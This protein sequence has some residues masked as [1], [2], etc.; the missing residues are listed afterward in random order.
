MIPRETV[1]KILDAAQIVEVVSDFVTLKKR[2][3]DF[4]ACCPFHNEKTP[5]FHVSQ[6]RGFYKCF[7]CGKS[8]T[9][10]GFVMEHETLS[11]VDA[12]KWLARKYHIEVVEKEETAEE[13]AARQRGESLMLVTQF[14]AEFFAKQ[15]REGEGRAVGYAY[16]KMRKLEDETITKFG[17]G[18]APKGRD[19]L[20]RAAREAGYKE[21]FLIEAGLSVKRDDGSLADRFFER[22]MFP[23]CSD[24]GRVIGFG[25]RTLKKDDNI[26]KYIN[27]SE[28]EIYKKSRVLYGMNFAKGEI[29]RKGKC[30]LVEGY[31]DVISMHQLGLTNVVASSGTALTEE[32]V[33]LIHKFTE[34]VT[35]IYDA[36]PAGIHAAL[37][38]IDLVLREGLN[39]KILLLP[40]GEDPD[41]FAHKKTLAEVGAYIEG[42]EQDFIGFKTD[43]L[44]GDAGDDPLK[45]AN[46]VND[47]ADTIAQ[48][49]D[50]VKRATYLESTSRRFGIDSDSI[51]RRISSTREKI[52]L[53][54]KRQREARRRAASQS[55]SSGGGVQDGSWQNGYSTEGLESWNVPEVPVDGGV[56]GSAGGS[57][58]VFNAPRLQPCERELLEFV[59]NSGQK[60]ME[61][62]SD[63]E[64]YSPE[65]VCVADFI[66]VAL[67]EDGQEFVNDIYRI[68]YEKYFEYY[69]EGLSQEKIVARLMESDDEAVATVTKDIVIPKYGLS[70]KR[71]EDSKTNDSTHL[72][73]FVPRSLLIYKRHRLD[74]RV[75]ELTAALA[76]GEE[77]VD[78]E[79]LMVELKEL[80]DMKN[81]L[82]DRLGRR[83]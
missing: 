76:S 45:K 37:R 20:S 80:N 21:E 62:D 35:I 24:G 32:Q 42:H 3:A 77:E 6:S 72:I 5:S 55:D 8:G 57:K 78:S 27:S 71:F 74:E 46:L 73:I 34:N 53:E 33:R 51:F 67:A 23:I 50:A 79:G 15:L 16:F 58:V 2:G 69:E 59:L 81:L 66:D 31:L 83:F 70:V 12:L 82:N 63:S 48:I 49:P 14:A 65:P 28:S 22:A 10:V 64:F 7:G 68:I 40:E 47:I 44:L 9:A 36:D 52:L 56:G 1:T 11:Y 61:F 39:V 41:S 18:W 60:P 17:L 4:V 43:L 54:E 75:L 30:I 38:G 19:S 13:L 25:G 26:A 29:V